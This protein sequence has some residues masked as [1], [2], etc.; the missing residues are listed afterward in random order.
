MSNEKGTVKF[1]R[2]RGRI[3]PIRPKKTSE[4]KK[5]LALIGAGIATTLAGAEVAGRVGMSGKVKG[6][7]AQAYVKAGNR[8]MSSGNIPAAMR[9]LTKASS[10]YKGMKSSF[11]FSDKLSKIAPLVGAGLFATGV[12]KLASDNKTDVGKDTAVFAAGAATFGLANFIVRKRM[13]PFIK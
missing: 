8:F 2:V 10:L 13:F 3:V 4:S 6:A 5:G 7:M 11:K 1:I 12:L 9:K